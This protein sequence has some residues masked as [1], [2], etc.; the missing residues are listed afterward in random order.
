MET[1]YRYLNARRLSSCKLP[2]LLIAYE[3]S[4]TVKY[5]IT[6]IWSLYTSFSFAFLIWDE[7]VVSKYT[8]KHSLNLAF[9]SIP[10]SEQFGFPHWWVPAS[11]FPFLSTHQHLPDISWHWTG[12]NEPS[13]L[14]LGTNKLIGVLLRMVTALLFS[15]WHG[16][17]VASRK[18][19]K[20][21][22]SALHCVFKKDFI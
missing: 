20:H 6:K 11:S 4:S 3:T 18:K 5:V 14:Q 15:F 16:V 1:V 7:F 22:K 8:R 9:S 10:V 19:K 2:S 13:R 17:I 21:E 12:S